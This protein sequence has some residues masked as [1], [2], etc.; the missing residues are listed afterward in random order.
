MIKYKTFKV[1]EEKEINEFLDKT[2]PLEN[3]IRHTN[4]NIIILYND[5]STSS[6][7][8]IKYNLSIGL[9]AVEESLRNN[10]FDLKILRL[11]QKKKRGGKEKQ[12]SLDIDI[13]KK[14]REIEFGEDL[15][16]CYKQS[17]EE[18]K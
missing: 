14:E 18:V 9:G 2:V 5:L 1:Q 7:A 16:T 17:I 12:E 11:Q 13:G 6:P 3:G 15:V 10:K 4:D 8:Y